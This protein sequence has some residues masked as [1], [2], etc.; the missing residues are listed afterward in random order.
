VYLTPELAAVITDADAFAD[1]CITSQV[2]LETDAAPDGAFVN[3]DVEGVAV[4]FAKATGQKC[5]RCWKI[6]P[7]V[8]THS[9]ADVCERCDQ[10]LS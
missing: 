7:D 4:I 2:K 9:H 8:G 10:A 5:G 6:L 3:A 1:L